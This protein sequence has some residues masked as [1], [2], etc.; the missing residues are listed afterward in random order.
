MM[1]KIVDYEKKK[2]EII[3]K[4]MN[5]FMQHGYYTTNL[6]GIAKEC[7]MGRTTLY[8]YFKNKEEI[9]LGVVQYI[10]GILESDYKKILEKQES[11][12]LEKIKQIFSTLVSRSYH[13]KNK[14]MMLSEL[15][16]ILQRDGANKAQ[17]I[18][19]QFSSGLIGKFKFLLQEGI[20]S[21]ELKDID[22]EIMACTLFALVKSMVFHPS[23]FYNINIE[24]YLRNINLLIDGL[25]A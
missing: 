24:D 20:K 16:L 14:M 6:S 11:S 8:Q 13:E 22:T 7:G 21:K 1:P 4:A 15:T 9:F 12:F 19:G 2:R 10:L 5:V 23:L 25:K 3:E 17:E 18:Q